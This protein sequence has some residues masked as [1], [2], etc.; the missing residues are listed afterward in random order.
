MT[1]T[2]LNTDQQDFLW[3]FVGDEGDNELIDLSGFCILKDEGVM[4][5]LIN[6]P[7]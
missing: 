1:T 7:L 5:C 2:L 4:I 6:S 3:I